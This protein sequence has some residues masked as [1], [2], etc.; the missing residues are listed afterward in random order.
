MSKPQKNTFG[1]NILDV[2]VRE[3]YLTSGALD[4]KALEK[5]LGELPDSADRSETLDLEQPALT[6]EGDE[7]ESE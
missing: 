6:G 2:R 3:R 5:Y 4:P 7:P 1:P